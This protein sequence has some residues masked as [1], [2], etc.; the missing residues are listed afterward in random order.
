VFDRPWWRAYATTLAGRFT[1]DTIHVR[2]LS[3]TTPDEE[4]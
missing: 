2:A 4:P 3:I 1:Q